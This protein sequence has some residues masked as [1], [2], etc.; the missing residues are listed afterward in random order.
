M[1]ILRLFLCKCYCRAWHYASC[2][3]IHS[4]DIFPWTFCFALFCTI[5][6]FYSI[7]TSWANTLFIG[8][9]GLLLIV[10]AKALPV[11]PHSGSIL[12]CWFIQIGAALL[13]PWQKTFFRDEHDTDNPKHNRDKKGSAKSDQLVQPV[14]NTAKEH[15]AASAVL[16][17][18]LVQFFD[19]RV[20]CDHGLLLHQHIRQNAH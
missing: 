20:P 1:N 19:E 5:F 2:P 3:L 15:T 7:G 6:I 13:N 4:F 10:L 8:W 14:R 17:R 18:G 16:N 11:F 12:F 9:F